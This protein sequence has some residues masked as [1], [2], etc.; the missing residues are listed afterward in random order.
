MVKHFIR[1]SCSMCFLACPTGLFMEDSNK[2]TVKD[3]YIRI[4]CTAEEKEKIFTNAELTKKNGSRYLLAV[5]LKQPIKTAEE[6]K[7]IETLLQLKADLARLGNLFKLYLDKGETRSESFNETF[8]NIKEI[9][10]KI[11]AI[12]EKNLK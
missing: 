6:H 1:T 12:L 2:K 11:G 5:G 7:N 10:S 4:R 3:T 8:K 9:S